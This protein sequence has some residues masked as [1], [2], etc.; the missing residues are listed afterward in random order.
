MQASHKLQE[1][2]ALVAR[3]NSRQRPRWLTHTHTTLVTPLDPTSR[4]CL[5]VARI[6]SLGKLRASVVRLLLAPSAALSG[7]ERALVLRAPLAH[8]V[9]AGEHVA[10]YLELGVALRLAI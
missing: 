5:A 2:D 9:V 3:A 6:S 1:A 4:K 10:P 7:L 8:A